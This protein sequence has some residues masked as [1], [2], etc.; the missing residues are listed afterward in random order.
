MIAV[1]SA[2]RAS[3]AVV[4]RAFRALAPRSPDTQ[5]LV[6]A[7]LHV[8]GRAPELSI[9][10]DHIAAR[11]PALPALT[12]YLPRGA[13]RWT[14]SYPDLAVHVVERAAPGEQENLESVVAELTRTELPDDAPHWRL[15]LLHG[16][17][18]QQYALLYLAHHYLQD[19]GGLL[20]TVESLFGP[21]ISAEAS[22]AVYHG[23]TRRLPAASDYGRCLTMSV[24]NVRQ[25]RK[26][27]VPH[28]R[29]T[30][31]RT[32]HWIP[33]PGNGS[34]GLGPMY[35]TWVSGSPLGCS[36]PVPVRDNRSV[37]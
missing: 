33:N 14:A 1:R 17:A 4:D 25:A 15:W 34:S 10:R 22:S 20:H 24:R 3:A 35:E 19:A 27:S 5:M 18:P 21:E 16:H 8:D 7:V 26:W 29:T 6:G 11:L 23:F 2:R 31:D 13:T 28:Y 36:T 30:P 9:L 32:L 12:S 37:S